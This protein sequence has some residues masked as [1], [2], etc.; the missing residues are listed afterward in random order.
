MVDHPTYGWPAL[1]KFHLK[2][3]SLFF[4]FSWSQITGTVSATIISENG[5]QTPHF[6][7]SC[8]TVNLC[9]VSKHKSGLMECS[10][11][12]LGRRHPLPARGPNICCHCVSPTALIKFQ[13]AAPGLCLAN[14]QFI[15][16]SLGSPLLPLPG[17]FLSSH[18]LASDLSLLHSSP[19]IWDLCLGP[20][21]SHRDWFLNNQC[22]VSSVRGLSVASSLN[23]PVALSI[24]VALS[25]N[26][27]SG[28]NPEPWL[29][30][31][32]GV[33]VRASHRLTRVTL[34]S[35]TSSGCGK[36]FMNQLSLSRPSVLSELASGCQDSVRLRGP[37]RLGSVT[38]PVSAKAA[39][40]W[41]AN[42]S[43]Y[44]SFITHTAMTPSLRLGFVKLHPRDGSR[45]QW[46]SAH[47]P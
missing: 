24:S 31:G 1:N 5:L 7:S 44:W 29:L 36:K 43:P 27:P 8:S 12:L 26:I 22:S 18:T 33:A 9:L 23:I 3:A 42:T 13:Q 6:G 45:W 41:P 19:K 2:P 10:W 15:S 39:S 30:R 20:S 47:V 46:V 35:C 28:S 34:G 38:P 40:F 14:T 16:I 32:W 37:Q 4:H 17:W 21:K 25:L 11:E